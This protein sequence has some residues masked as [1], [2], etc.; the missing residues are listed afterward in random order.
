MD[1]KKS[2]PQSWPECPALITLPISY[3]TDNGTQTALEHDQEAEINSRVIILQKQMLKYNKET[4]GRFMQ[5]L[6]REHEERIKENNQLHYE[7]NNMKA[8]VQGMEKNLAF[9]KSSGNN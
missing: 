5:N 4:L 8:Q 2:R 7:I 1:R 3:V 9:M 6:T